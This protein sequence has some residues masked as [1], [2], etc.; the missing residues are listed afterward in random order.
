MA[1]GERLRIARKSKGLTQ[2]QVYKL[3]GIGDTTISNYENDLSSPDPETLKL[4][5]ELYEIDPRYILG[6]A[7]GGTK[8]FHKNATQ[9]GEFI[10]LPLM[11][12]VRAG[13]GGSIIQEI[14]GYVPTPIEATTTGETYF[15]LLVKGDSMYPALNDGDKVMVRQ[16]TSVDSGDLAV[17]VVDEDE[18][19]VK[20]VVYGEDWIELH[21][22]NHNYS[23]RR[24]EGRDVLRIQ[25]L[26]K[27]IK[28]QRDW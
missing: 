17:V 3:S 20:K 12:T 7:D 15:W 14:I 23:P 5:C 1:L 4:L 6:M 2:K 21:S 19:L 24:F 11:G 26:G 8:W 16:Q 18:G 10:K 28:S 9:A 25:V 27:V 22:F 13:V